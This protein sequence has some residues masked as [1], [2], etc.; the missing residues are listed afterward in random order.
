MLAPVGW[1]LLLPPLA[2]AQQTIQ[3]HPGVVQ[4]Q[5]VVN[6]S[7]LA[8]REAAHPPTFGAKVHRELRAPKP[9]T[10][11]EGT[12]VRF[13]P[14]PLAAAFTRGLPSPRVAS[15]SLAANFLALGESGNAIPPDTQGTAGPNHLVVTLNSQVAVQDRT[16]AN[17]ELVT[18]DGFW[19]SAGANSTTDPR[20]VYDP[21]NNRWIISTAG[22]FMGPQAALLV[23]VTQT[24]DPTGNWNLYNIAVDPTGKTF[25][26]FPILGF[27]SK[28][29]IINCNIFDIAGA[30]TFRGGKLF[31]FD[32]FNL[33]GHGAGVPITLD[34]Q[35]DS[36]VTPA[37]TY[38]NSLST[39][40]LLEEYDGN[41]SGLGYLRLWAI[42]GPV[43][44]PSLTSLALIAT[45]QTWDETG[46]NGPQSGTATGIDLDDA[47]LTNVIYRN[48]TLW[49]T[50]HIF[51]P[52]GAPSDRTMVQWWQVG[53]DASILQRGLIDN[54][55]TSV[56][57]YYPSI[58]VNRGEDVLIGYTRSSVNEFAGSFYS[59][60]K[61]SDPPNTMEDEA[62]LKAGEATYTKDGGSG[63]VRWGDYSNSAVDPLDDSGLWTIQEYAASGSDPTGTWSTWW[64]AIGPAG[65]VAQLQASATPQPVQAGVALADLAVFSTDSNG[66]RATSYTGTVHFS[67]ND[68]AAVLP[69]DFTF[70][71]ADN[72]LHDFSGVTF[73]K[74]GT[75]SLTV[76][77]TTNGALVNTINLAVN[78]GP[79]AALGVGL[80]GSAVAG[81]PATFT[82]T[83][84]DAFQNAVTS[85]TGTVQFSS[86]D[87]QAV[88]PAAYTF[89]AGDMGAHSFQATLKTAGRQ[90]LLVQDKNGLLGSG[91]I[92]VLAAAASSLSL[93]TPAEATR[94][95]AFTALL[96][97]RD[98]FGNLASGYTGTVQ[99]S[100]S[101]GAAV[102]PANYT[103]V[104]GDGGSHSF[105]VTLN[106]LSPPAIILTASDASDGLTANSSIDVLHLSGTGKDVRVRLGQTFTL[107]LASFSEDATGT[108]VINIDW[109]DG[110]APTSGTAQSD[111]A[112][113]FIVTGSHQYL[114]PPEEPIT[115]AIND[116]SNGIGPFTIVDQVRMWP[117]TE[118]H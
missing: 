45:T 103:F 98:P 3:G 21:Y 88:L 15:P 12:P 82:V 99:F 30:G 60:R 41:M 7:E 81:A 80:T 1:W 38:D 115:V 101:D 95:K 86:S 47:S 11:P 10:L 49:T 58:A 87:P 62:L 89:V 55:D 56:F 20:V 91:S 76:K 102:L 23:G 31:V 84:Q 108:I 28:W 69:S 73:F 110:S 78:A 63:D 26:D 65:P 18:L 114:L 106:A 27:N 107:L 117:K 48:G 66:R 79:L 75:V 34:T 42:D 112:G 39:E 116:I 59:F 4:A 77:D 72:G 104:S 113:G 6:L 43:S 19:A 74:A 70:G 25:C 118:S 51:V 24:G 105:S 97:A 71:P 61:F 37:S 40:Y 92:N 111:G 13:T 50:H 46:Q 83:A 85:Y 52:Q 36:N 96:R 35:G 94:G 29:V 14:E 22:N 93:G 17:L 90:S 8:A 100:S 32:K 44:A 57:R 2:M 16:G 33:Y 5:A 54:G 53:T 64:G 9:H 68:P 109:G 67:S